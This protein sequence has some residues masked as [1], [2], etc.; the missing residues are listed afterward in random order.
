MELSA[1]MTEAEP[2]GPRVNVPPVRA[3]EVPEDGAAKVKVPPATGSSGLL[4]VTATASGLAKAVPSVVC[5]R[6]PPATE[7]IVK[8]W[9]WK[10]Q[11]QVASRAARHAGRW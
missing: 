6:V 9:L 2:S 5:W 8:P 7:V 10:R 11:Y 1:A 3:A 4:A